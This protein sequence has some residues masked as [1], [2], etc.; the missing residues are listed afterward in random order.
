MVETSVW[1]DDGEEMSSVCQMSF[2]DGSDEAGIG[3]EA[4]EEGGLRAQA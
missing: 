1:M 3:E 2:V 4:K